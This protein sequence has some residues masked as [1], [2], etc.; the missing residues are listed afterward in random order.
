[1]AQRL[2]RG[3]EEE[4]EMKVEAM[5]WTAGIYC[6]A[7]SCGAVEQRDQVRD[8]D[9]PE[10]GRALQSG[11]ETW[12]SDRLVGLSSSCKEEASHFG[13]KLSIRSR[14]VFEHGTWGGRSAGPS[15]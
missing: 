2:I 14:I 9:R 8:S 11:D 12:L 15:A 13:V 7:S 6:R 1:M 10:C 4:R 5:G 3:V